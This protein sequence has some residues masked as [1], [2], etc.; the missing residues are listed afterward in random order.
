[1]TDKYPVAP[2]HGAEYWHHAKQ[3]KAR[4]RKGGNARE[5]QKPDLEGTP[6][7]LSQREGAYESGGSGSLFGPSHALPGPPAGK[8]ELGGVKAPPRRKV[9]GKHQLHVHEE[10]R[11]QWERKAKLSQSDPRRLSARLKSELREADRAHG[12][13]HHGTRE[14][15]RSDAHKVNYSN[16]HFKGLP[17]DEVVPGGDNSSAT[18]SLSAT[19]QG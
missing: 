14:H 2:D 4:A 19:E 3:E 17:Q 10:D 5:H 1:M 9:Q 11:G 18:H 7:A 13:H 16:K 12:K 6:W 15:P 8:T